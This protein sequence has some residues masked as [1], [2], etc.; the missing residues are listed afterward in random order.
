MVMLMGS[1]LFLG[2]A[3][4]NRTNE[5]VGTRLGSGASNVGEP[6]TGIRKRQC[7]IA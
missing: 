6:Y 1:F 7:R 2:M 5:G 4:T 3:S